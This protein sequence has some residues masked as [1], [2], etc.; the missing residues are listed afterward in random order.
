MHRFI[1]SILDNKELQTDHK[2]GDGL[3]NQK[4]NL[5]VCNSFQNQANRKLQKNNRTGFKGLLKKC[6]RWRALITT[7]RKR[8]YLG[9]FKTK[10]DAAKAYDKAAQK[11]FG[12]FARLNFPK[13]IFMLF[14]AFLISGT[15]FG[16]SLPYSVDE[17][18]TAIYQAEGAEKAVKPFGILSVPCNGYEECRRICKN[19]VVNNFKRFNDYGYKTHSD[20]LS[21]LSSRYAP[22]GAKNDPQNLNRNWLKN[23]HYF[24]DN[25]KAVQS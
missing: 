16:N 22:I 9:S 25:P 12:E 3:N 6:N 13:E 10:Q 8:I 24:L 20:Y 18:V 14:L 2:D 7:N 11:Y 1:L 4:Y 15:A 5:R 17:I 23:V 19:T 21:F